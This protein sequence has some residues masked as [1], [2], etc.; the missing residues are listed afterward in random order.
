MS[1][2]GHIVAE[3]IITES[4]IEEVPYEFHHEGRIRD[5]QTNKNGKNT[6]GRENA[7]FIKD[8]KT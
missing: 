2:S 1:N 8:S 6:L 3:D 7:A 4:F 5:C